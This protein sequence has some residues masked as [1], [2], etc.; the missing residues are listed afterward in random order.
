MDTRLDS[1]GPTKPDYTIRRKKQRNA[2]EVKKK[3]IETTILD[4]LVGGTCKAC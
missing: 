2:I 4:P 1:K 3:D